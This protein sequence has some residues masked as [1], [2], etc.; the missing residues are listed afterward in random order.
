LDAISVL[1][2][3]GA[4]FASLPGVA[5]LEAGLEG[6]WLLVL[7]G[8]AAL[9]AA[10]PL[11]LGLLELMLPEFTSLPVAVLPAVPLVAGPGV[12]PGI[13]LLCS[14]GGVEV[15]GVSLVTGGVV[16]GCALLGLLPTALLPAGGSFP[17]ADG[18]AAA[19]PAVPAAPTALCDSLPAVPLFMAL[20]PLLEPVPEQ[21]LAIIRTLET[22]S[23]LLAVEL[24]ELCPELLDAA[25]DE[26]LL[27]GVPDTAIS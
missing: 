22:V 1:L 19:A 17:V 18:V 23:E 8:A 6:A 27:L 14:F 21:L 2:A 13:V 12:A 4:A 9:D 3:G 10:S 16:C 24:V 25:A 5:L 11:V 15:A 7:P 20:G 26:L